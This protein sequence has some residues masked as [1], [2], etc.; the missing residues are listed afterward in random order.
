MERNKRISYL[1]DLVYY[2]MG[3]TKS[4]TLRI[5]HI[6]DELKILEMGYEWDVF[7]R[8]VSHP[9][10]RDN[11]NPNDNYCVFLDLDYAEKL[12]LITNIELEDTHRLDITLEANV[13]GYP[14]V[15]KIYEILKDYNQ[16][17]ILS[18]SLLLYFYH[19]NLTYGHGESIEEVIAR[20]AS[21]YRFRTIEEYTADFKR[22]EPLLQIENR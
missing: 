6:A 9:R 1:V 20:V 22:L 7:S 15:K 11:Y 4:D 8:G 16:K 5:I 12:H 17:D 3:A 10:Y 19:N 14:E 18:A 2:F 21:I 13:S